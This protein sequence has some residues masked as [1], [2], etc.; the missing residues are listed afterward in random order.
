MYRF[1]LHNDHHDLYTTLPTLST[2]HHSSTPFISIP[3]LRS[4]TA[5]GPLRPVHGPEIARS[6]RITVARLR[7][8]LRFGRRGRRLRGRRLLGLSG[9]LLRRVCVCRCSDGAGAPREARGGGG[10]AGGPAG[11]AGAGEGRPRGAGDTWGGAGDGD[12][13]ARG[14][15]AVLVGYVGDGD[16]GA[17]GGGVGVGT[18]DLHGFGFFVPGVFEFALFFC[19]Y[20]VGRFVAVMVKLFK[21]VIFSFLIF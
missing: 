9:R 10:E 19:C 4:K 1:Y 13:G 21:S 11:G 12:V 2:P 18:A 8:A 7:C 14:L 17:V 3:P 5:P 16:E 15:E 6:L 20:S